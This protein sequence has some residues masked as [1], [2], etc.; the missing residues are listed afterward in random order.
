M[1][2]SRAIDD[3]TA[4]FS[5]ALE[6]V[7]PRRMMEGAVELDGNHLGFRAGTESLE[8]D[9]RDFDRILAFGAGKASARMALG[10]EAILGG[11]LS[12]GI[13]VVKTGHVENLSRITLLEAAHPVPDESSVAAARALLGLGRDADE[14]TLFI[15]LTSGGGFFAPVRAAS[16]P[17]PRGQALDHP[18]PAGMRRPDP[19]DQLRPQAPLRH[20]G[21]GGSPRLWRPPPW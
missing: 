1:S 15:G 17:E 6:R 21:R 8:L 12:G 18:P 13:V 7:D 9:L 14:R 10:L 20:Q 19:G 5:A 2:R 11:K 4:V 3:A 16:R